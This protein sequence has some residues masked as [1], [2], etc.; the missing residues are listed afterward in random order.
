MISRI[1]VPK[2]EHTVY[3]TCNSSFRRVF[4]SLA[5]INPVEGESF[6]VLRI[7]NYELEELVRDYNANRPKGLENTELSKMDGV[8]R[9]NVD[10][11]SF[12]LKDIHLRTVRGILRLAA[13]LPHREGEIVISK[14]LHEFTI[15]LETEERSP[16]TSLSF[17]KGIL[18][19]TFETTH[20][21]FPHSRRIPTA[22]WDNDLDRDL[23]MSR[24]DLNEQSEERLDLMTR[25][26]IRGWIDGEGYINSGYPGKSGPYLS[27]GQKERAPLQVME[28]SFWGMGI[29]ARIYSHPSNDSYV[30]E[31]MGWENVARVIAEVG[32]FRTANR[33]AQVEEFKTNLAMPRK[34]THASVKRARKILG[35]S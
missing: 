8:L 9:M 3:L 23:A 15:A 28:D 26:E 24:D 32:P 21:R 1:S 33:K 16:V 22:R 30:L 13:K 31:V 10:G 29:P 19:L 27:V 20:S 25:R 7:R 2:V 11:F 14:R 34:K 35:I 6:R 5:Q 18:V 17:A 4:V 12:E